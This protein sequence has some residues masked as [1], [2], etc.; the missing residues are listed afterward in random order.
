M[1]ILDSGFNIKTFVRTFIER[2]SK[3]GFGY[4]KVFFRIPVNYLSMFIRNKWFVYRGK[5]YRYF[6]HPYHRTWMTERAIEI[7]IIL[8]MLKNSDGS[9]L[10]IG[11]VLN[12]YA[13]IP[14]D[15]VDK[16]EKAPGVVNE[17][18]VSFKTDKK[19]DSIVSIST[20]E[21]VGWDEDKSEDKIPKSLENLKKHLK[22]NGRIIITVPVNY[23]PWLDKMM[24]KGDLFD[25]MHFMKRKL[26][27]QWKESNWQKIKNCGFS[28][29]AR[30]LAILIIKK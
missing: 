3:E 27:N 20:I 21:H 30:G 22:K 19:Y 8:E 9:I 17:D 24:E 1:K 11:N 29:D 16:F 7:P 15:V 18:V 12:H 13:N 26:F 23:N 2:F 25:E 6:Y 28:E 4:L 5:K 10:E 14:H